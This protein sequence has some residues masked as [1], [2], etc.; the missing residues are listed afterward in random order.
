VSIS[1]DANR[2]RTMDK[3]FLPLSD[4]AYLDE[5]LYSYKEVND[6]AR[7]GLII[8][9]FKLPAGKYHVTSSS[10]M[11]I[12]PQGYSDVAPDMFYFSP[13][14]KLAGSN[15]YPAQADVFEILFEMNWQRWSR[16]ADESAW[17]GGVDGIHSYLQRVIKALHVA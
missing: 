6:G 17:R 4:R 10:L 8:S 1:T 11:I 12:I 7:N 13:A 16:H 2:I 3:K 14:L 15:S 5:K 9:D